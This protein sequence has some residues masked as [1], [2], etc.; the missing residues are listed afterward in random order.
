MLKRENLEDLPIEI[1]KLLNFNEE[2]EINKDLEEL[3]KK[4]KNKKVRKA[5]ILLHPTSL[6]GDYSIGTLGKNCFDFIDFLYDSSQ[7][8]WQIFPLGPTGYGDSPYQCLSAFA[9][10]PY[11]IDLELLVKEELLTFDEI[12]ILKDDSNRVDYGKLYEKKLPLLYKAYDRKDGIKEEFRAFKIENDYWLDDY[13]NFIA[14]KKYFGGKSWIEWDEDIRNR[15]NSALEKY[16]QKL[17]IEI[18]KEKFLQFL[19]FRQ[20]IKVKEYANSKNIEI[21]GDIPIFVSMDSA[22]VW[23][24]KELFVFDKVAGV[25]PDYFSSTGQLWGN[26]L[27]NWDY[28]R[29][30]HYKWWLDRVSSNLSLFDIIR[31]DHFRGFESYWAIPA[32]EKTAINGKWEKAYGEELFKA[33]HKEF[34]NIKI[35]AEDLG[36]ITEEVVELKDKFNYPGMKILQFA[37]DKDPDNDYLPH[38]YNTNCVVYTGTHDNDTTLGWYSNISEDEKANVRDYLDLANDDGIS[39]HLIRLAHRS[40]ANTSI[41]P[42]QDY[43]AR[44][45]D[46]RMNTPGLASGNWQWRMTKDDMSKDLSNS[47]SHITKLYGR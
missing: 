28:L 33:I 11:L 13:A 31:L 12:E 26:P 47:I 18:D 14:I 21:I 10:N 23:A 38:N 19:F 36:S 32:N 40:V 34:S 7:R 20:W 9:G 27:Y 37:F 43:L 24:N 3:S 17:E 25:P 35:I 39:W 29:K 45:S 2:K 30:T 16:A 6:A 41:I 4:L 5:G 22:D 42:M 1:A 46:T 15:K 44:S 8:L